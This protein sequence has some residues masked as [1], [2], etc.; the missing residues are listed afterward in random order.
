[1]TANGALVAAAQAQAEGMS[2]QG[3]LSHQLPGGPSLEAK[4]RAAGYVGWSAL[5]EAVAQGPASP[6]EVL[7]LWMGSES[8]RASILNPVYAEA[9]VAHYYST[10]TGHYWA[11]ELGVR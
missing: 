11:L 6:D 9:G 4:V 1:L 2:S 7:A 8:H 10:A 3:I 5:G